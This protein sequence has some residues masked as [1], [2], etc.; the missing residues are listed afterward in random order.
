MG[1]MYLIFKSTVDI[2]SSLYEPISIL[3]TS[4][5]RQPVVFLL[6]CIKRLHPEMNVSRGLENNGILRSVLSK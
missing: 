2:L 4:R 5:V 6:E 1:F 3:V